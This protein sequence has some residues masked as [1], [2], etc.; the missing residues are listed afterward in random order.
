MICLL[1]QGRPIN[2]KVVKHGPFV[3][4]SSEEIQEAFQNYHETKF[5]GWPWT[6][7]GVVFP[8]DKGRFARIRGMECKERQIL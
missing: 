8:R 3:M 7:N 1:L 5:G 6:E 4:N 2:E